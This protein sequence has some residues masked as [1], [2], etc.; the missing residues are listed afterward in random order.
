MEGEKK[1]KK[2]DFSDSPWPILMEKIYVVDTIRKK[3]F[4]YFVQKIM[5][6]KMF[7]FFKIFF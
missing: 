6:K 7:D 5:I 3:F 2:C 1:I 4:K